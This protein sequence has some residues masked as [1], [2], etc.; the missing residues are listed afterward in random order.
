MQLQGAIGQFK[1]VY[2][3]L[4]PVKKITLFSLIGGAIAGLTLI[5]ILSGRPD[6]QVLFSGLSAED[7]GAI[8]GQLK[9]KKIPFQISSNGGAILIPKDI[10]YETRMEFAS[11]GLP[12]GG[13]VGFE[14]FD[15]SKLGMTEFVQNVNYQR[16]IQGELSR[17]INRF[18]EVESSRVHIV[19]PPKSLFVENEEAA[20][21]SV[22]IKFRPRKSLNADQIQGIVHLISSSVSGL[23]PE[24]ITIVDSL[25]NQIASQK[26]KNDIDR[27]RTDQLAYQE[28]LERTLENRVKTMLENALGPNKAIVRLSSNMD[29]KK[30][31]KTEERFYPDNKVV[32]SEQISNESS[33]KPEKTAMGVPGSN[34]AMTDKLQQGI[35]ASSAPTSASAGFQKQHSTANYEIG[36][37]TSH[38]IEPIGRITGISVAVLVDGAYKTVKGEDG[39]SKV[40]YVPRSPEE[41]S[42]I[43]SIVMR[44]VN[45][46]ASRGDEVEVVNMPFEN[47]ELAEVQAGEK[48][49]GWISRLMQYSAYIKYAFSGAFMLLTFIFVIRP[50]IQ[51]LTAESS[52]NAQLLGHLPRTV[53]EIEREYGQSPKTLPISNQLSQ[54]AMADNQAFVEVLREWMKQS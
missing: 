46:T 35:D 21:A 37:M 23:K 26:E 8:I 54:L 43:K 45:Y 2:A 31:E 19:M 29:F 40:E 20:R 3:G 28:K 24:N 22:V 52:N 13:G 7:S 17:T 1:A 27:A 51:W 42:K 18:E 14:I 25:G 5:M 15:N 33:V 53:N 6:Y 50:L 16:A 11:Q 30:Q 48:S 38:T 47:S 10:V 39:K 34:A 9:T 41:I 44:A 49:N 4:N 32:R 36:K 12:Q